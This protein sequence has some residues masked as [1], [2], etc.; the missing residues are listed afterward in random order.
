[1]GRQ[2]WTVTRRIAWQ[3]HTIRILCGVAAGIL[4]AGAGILLVIA[5]IS[6]PAGQGVFAL[7][8]LAILALIG[9]SCLLMADVRYPLPVLVLVLSVLLCLAALWTAVSGVVRGPPGSSVAEK[10]VTA[11]FSLS[12]N[13]VETS[14]PLSVCHYQILTVSTRCS[15]G[16][17]IS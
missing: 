1:M 10:L 15:W 13:R 8:G 5:S 16:A 3:E 11:A 14:W 12:R 7:L 17:N 2:G 4:G 6:E 9:G